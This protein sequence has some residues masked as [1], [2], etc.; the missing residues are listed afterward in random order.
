MQARGFYLGSSQPSDV[1]AL[2]S[3]GFFLPVSR[4]DFISAGNEV[5]PAP[6]QVAT[7]I[8]ITNPKLATP[9]FSKL[10]NPATQ[11]SRKLHCLARA[12]RQK[13]GRCSS[14]NRFKI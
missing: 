9:R 4:D 1:I 2:S 5:N 11:V 7:S 8:A 6:M 3:L 12:V 14:V 13:P 10:P